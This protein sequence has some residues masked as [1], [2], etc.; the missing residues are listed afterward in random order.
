MTKVEVARVRVSRILK[1]LEMSAA[2]R[3]PAVA[4]LSTVSYMLVRYESKQS[5]V[6][7]G[8]VGG[9]SWKVTL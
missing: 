2:L 6:T 9:R 3:D 7:F 1:S 5:S 8:K 4:A